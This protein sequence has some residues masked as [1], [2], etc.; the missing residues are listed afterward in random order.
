MFKKMT[1]PLM[2]LLACC[3]AL[4]AAQITPDPCATREIYS[5]NTATPV[6]LLSYLDTGAEHDWRVGSS[7]TTNTYYTG[8]IYNSNVVLAFRLPA[9]PAGQVVGSAGLHWFYEENYKSRGYP[10]DL[11][12]LGYRAG[13]T[14]PCDVVQLSDYYAGTA[15]TNPNVTLLGEKVNGHFAVGTWRGISD[16]SKVMAAYLQSLY[17][18]GAQANDWVLFRLNPQ[19]SYIGYARH[20]ILSTNY[21][22]S[23]F[24]PYLEYE[25]MPD[26]L[27]YWKLCTI[28]GPYQA[29]ATGPA[30]L[31]ESLEIGMANINDVYHDRVV[32]FPFQIPDLNAGEYVS[33]ASFTC[34]WNNRYHA[35]IQVDM[36]GL[37]YR[38]TK[39]FEGS[40]FW[41]G[42]YAPLPTE[43]PNGTP[44]QS[45]LFEDVTVQGSQWSVD[46]EGASRLGCYIQAQRD[47]GATS[48]D[49]LF[50][51]MNG[52]QSFVENYKRE[53]VALPAEMA[54]RVSTTS[55]TCLP[56]PDTEWACPNEIG[57]YPTNMLAD[58]NGDCQTDMQDLIELASTW[59]DCTAEPASLY[60]P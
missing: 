18:A 8:G 55:P 21:P 20:S 48:S 14:D 57:V 25:M 23:A 26:T 28:D 38:A 31:P 12:G 10:A 34:I 33:E 52:R 58:I 51:R 4:M 2:I 36:Y 49:Y 16:P 6:I 30:A 11:Y 43:D 1:L 40:D 5:D 47:A 22:D 15:D 24:H 19:G 32:I 59:T 7:D 46:T 27:G 3:T 41:V 44:I 45:D 29:F 60:C 42:F 17:D 54:V 13:S 37:D 9:L 35:G 56:A 50:L 53:M 39:D